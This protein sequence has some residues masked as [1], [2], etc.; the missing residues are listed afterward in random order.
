MAITSEAKP[1]CFEALIS[2]PIFV[3]SSRVAAEIIMREF[4]CKGPNRARKLIARLRPMS[5]SAPEQHM[6]CPNCAGEMKSMTVE[7][8]LA[9]PETIDVCAT[10]QGFWFDK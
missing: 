2:S 1:K 5:Y 10:C 6:N 8:H 9:A 7:A 4:M 3:P